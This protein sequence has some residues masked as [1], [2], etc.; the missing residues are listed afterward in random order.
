MAFVDDGTT[1]SSKFG[2]NFG[3]GLGVNIPTDIGLFYPMFNVRFNLMLGEDENK[4]VQ[5][6]TLDGQ[7]ATPEPPIDGHPGVTSVDLADTSV[8]YSIPR[9]TLVFY[10][11]F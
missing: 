2:I 5:R 1:S 7:L 4:L 9:F 8:L 6:Y 3:L 11:K 10:P